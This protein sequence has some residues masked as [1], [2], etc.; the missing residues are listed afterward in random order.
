MPINVPYPITSP[1]PVSVTHTPFNPAAGAF[2]AYG[3]LPG[4]GQSQPQLPALGT[5]T[6][7]FPNPF[8]QAPAQKKVQAAGPSP[9]YTPAQ[10]PATKQILSQLI[11]GWSANPQTGQLASPGEMSGRMG[12]PSIQSY[13][14]HKGRTDPAWKSSMEQALTQYKALQ[15]SGRPL[16]NINDR[17]W[18]DNLYSAPSVPSGY[19]G[20][21]GGYPVPPM[22][23]FTP[24]PPPGQ[25]VVNPGKKFNTGPQFANYQYDSRGNVMKDAQ[26]NPLY[27]P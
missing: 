18:Y 19:W 20:G 2:N 24:P 11:A 13:L 25:S 22:S 27:A 21:G 23:T 16:P 12:P 4:M 7:M 5:I 3:N 26:G 6:G 15:S 17:S 14:L 10:Q 8:S 1:S 9:W